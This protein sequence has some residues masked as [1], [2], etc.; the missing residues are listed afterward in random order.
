MAKI[1]L[2]QG[3]EPRKRRRKPGDLAQLRAVLWQTILEVE[4]LME[5][6]LVDDYGEEDPRGHQALVLKAAHALAQLSGSYSRILES[7]D[8]ER[9][10]VALE[11]A[12]LQRR[13]GHHV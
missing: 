8:L 5:A 2:A 13:N 6:P 11:A 9:R 10:I 3:L 7:G 4:A 12:V 1:R